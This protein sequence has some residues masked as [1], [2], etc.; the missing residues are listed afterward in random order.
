M[1]KVLIVEDDAL[2][3]NIL[4]TKLSQEG[5]E[6]LIAKD[7]LEAQEIF[8]KENIDLVLLD[9]LLPRKSGFEFLKE[10]YKTPKFKQTQIIIISNLSGKDD[11]ERGKSLGA[12]EFLIKAQLSLD[13]LVGTVKKYLKKE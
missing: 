7:G 11:I 2:L 4:K 8:M 5:Y 10:I 6:V 9:I 12:V 13:D 1:A 3:L